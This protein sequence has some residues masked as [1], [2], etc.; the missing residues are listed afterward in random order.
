MALPCPVGVV[1]GNFQSPKDVAAI[2]PFN[3]RIPSD[4]KRLGLSWYS[5]FRLVGAIN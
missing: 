3:A 5:N 2:K 1:N 4:G